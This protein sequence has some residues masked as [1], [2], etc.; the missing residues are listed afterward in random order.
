VRKSRLAVN[1]GLL[2][3]EMICYCQCLNCVKI[4]RWAWW[5]PMGR[6]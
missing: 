1:L 6:G 5:G 4:T 2:H 3:G